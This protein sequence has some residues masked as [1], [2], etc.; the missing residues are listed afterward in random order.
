M[1]IRGIF[2]CQVTARAAHKHASCVRALSLALSTSQRTHYVK[3]QITQTIARKS[4]ALERVCDIASC[5]WLPACYVY[6]RAIYKI[7]DVC[8]CVFLNAR[9]YLNY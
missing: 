4:R 8:V 2:P 6:Q 9:S 3:T 7:V 1:F 5:A